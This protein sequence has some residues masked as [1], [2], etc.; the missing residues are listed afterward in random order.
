MSGLAFDT[1][2]DVLT[3]A[4]GDGTR[5]FAERNL[6]LPRRHL[7]RL[8]PT[9]AEVI[10]EVEMGLSDL[11]TVSVGIGPGSFT[12]LRIGVATARGLAQALGTSLVGLP[13]LEVIAAGAEQSG[14]VCSIV[15]SRP[16]EFYYCFYAVENGHPKQISQIAAGSILEVESHAKALGGPVVFTGPGV[17]ACKTDLGDRLANCVF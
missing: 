2:T 3:V 8:V 7:E 11:Q 5:I 12:G 13:S 16:G 9:I 4:L 6:R 10:D 17:A 1:S 14:T 15:G